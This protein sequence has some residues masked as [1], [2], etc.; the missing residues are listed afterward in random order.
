MNKVTWV[1]AH[2]T[3]KVPQ[4][5]YSLKGEERYKRLYHFTSFDTFVKIWLSKRLL[6]APVANVNDI[7]EACWSISSSNPQQLPLY[8]AYN[9][10][11]NE[12]KQISLSMD[13]DSATKGWMSPFMWGVYGDKRKGVCIEIDYSK[14]NFRNT[15]LKD[16]V[17]YKKILNPIELAPEMKSMKDILVY[18]KRYRKRI[19]FTKQD[20]WSKEHEYRIVSREDDFLDISDAITAV[21]LT[22]YDST[23]CKFT[24]AL[25]NGQIPVKYVHFRNGEFADSMDSKS[26]RENRER[27]LCDQ[28]N[29]LQKMFQQAKGHYLMHKNDINACLLLSEFHDI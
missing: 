12:Y 19:F 1:Q 27:A 14:L 24:E 16:V 25:V 13:K 8:Y 10:L 21:Y 11:R 20:D 2:L 6:F 23:E 26:I 5:V 3:V 28:N 17:A 18:L 15:M 7:K 4:K 9:E 29:C 22:S